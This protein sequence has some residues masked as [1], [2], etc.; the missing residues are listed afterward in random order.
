MFSSSGLRQHTR[1]QI[2]GADLGFDEIRNFRRPDR[3]G[4]AGHQ[5]GRVI[6]TRPQPLV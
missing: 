1:T 2:P 3:N 4:G 6:S 5:A